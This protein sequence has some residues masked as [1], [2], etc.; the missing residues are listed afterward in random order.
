MVE[1]FTQGTVD[2]VRVD[3]AMVS[4]HLQ[5]LSDVLKELLEQ[6]QP[7]TV[8]DMQEV[9][10]VDSEGLELL[11]DTQIDFERRGG[12]L[13]LAA[14]NPL[15]KDILSISGLANQLEIHSDV[16]TAV[17]SFVQ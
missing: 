11:L 1:R 15:C 6:G 7:R 12:A 8:L 14:P 2:V 13:K 3:D 10:L 17:G 16:K 5:P 9:P 4:E